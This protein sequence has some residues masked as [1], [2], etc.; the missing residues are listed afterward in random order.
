MVAGVAVARMPHTFSSVPACVLA[1]GENKGLAHL[2]WRLPDCRGYDRLWTQ[3]DC[4]T[5]PPNTHTLMKL[6][7]KS[8]TVKWD[9]LSSTAAATLRNDGLLSITVSPKAKVTMET[10][11]WTLH[12][13]S[14]ETYSVANWHCWSRWT[15]GLD[16]MAMQNIPTS[17]QIK[18]QPFAVLSTFPD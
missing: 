18:N 10:G 7:L 16:S 13:H 6:K 1:S 4:S 9:T 15:C 17:L 12:T 14:K 2:L 3:C 5:A 8:P 11:M